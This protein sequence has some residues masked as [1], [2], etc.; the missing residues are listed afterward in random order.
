VAGKV[1]DAPTAFTSI[2]LLETVSFS[3]SS[4]SELVSEVLNVRVTLARYGLSKS[5]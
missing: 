4:I 2:S 5:E 3:L 1:L